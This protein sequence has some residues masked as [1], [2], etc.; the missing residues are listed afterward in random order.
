MLIEHSVRNNLIPI[1]MDKSVTNSEH[2]CEILLR[3]TIRKQHERLAILLIIS[4]FRKSR[5]IES[6]TCL[7]VS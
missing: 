4:T 2:Y 6:S 5:L 7:L 1:P 3:G